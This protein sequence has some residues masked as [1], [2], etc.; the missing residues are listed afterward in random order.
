[1]P[2]PLPISQPLLERDDGW[3]ILQCLCNS[4]DA[5]LWRYLVYDDATAF[6][7]HRHSD[8]RESIIVTVGSVK[9]TAFDEDMEVTAE[10]HLQ[11]GGGYNVSPGQWHQIIVNRGVTIFNMLWTPREVGLKIVA[12]D[13]EEWRSPQLTGP[14][15]LRE[16]K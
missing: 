11:D 8:I 3:G 7:I 16:G 15:Q 12:A 6:P 10:K 14:D 2:I 5:I 1:M 13:C 9:L 4:P